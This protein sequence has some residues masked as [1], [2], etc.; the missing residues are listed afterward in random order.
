MN[1]KSLILTVLCTLPLLAFSEG[2]SL[3]QC[4][5]YANKANG[6]I[7]NANYD[8]EIAGHKVKE[9]LGT[10][11]PQI[12]GSASYTNNLLLATQLIPNFLDPTSTEMLKL[13]FGTKHNMSGS[14]QLTQ[15]LFDPTF[16]LALKASKLSE[17]QA[18]QSLKMTKEQSAYSISVTYYQTLVIGKQLSTL[19][20]TL[21]TSEKLL[22]STKLRLKNGMAKQIDV[23]KIKVSYNNLKS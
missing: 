14:L 23:D 9:T 6:N 13:Q 7:V 18:Q 5:D 3:K 1:K 19:R 4:I 16:P 20:S 11:L 10:V 22:S 8:V 2:F 12:D 21:K 15:K 17:D